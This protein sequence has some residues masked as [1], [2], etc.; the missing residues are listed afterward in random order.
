MIKK[1]QKQTDLL[2]YFLDSSANDVPDR[3]KVVESDFHCLHVGSVKIRMPVFSKKSF[4]T[5]RDLGESILWHGREKVVFN[6]EIEVGHPPIDERV[7]T[8]VHRVMRSVGD[9]VD[10][11]VLRDGRQMRVRHCKVCEN[12]CRSNP[13]VKEVAC[14][15]HAPPKVVLVKVGDNGV[16]KSDPSCFCPLLFADDASWVQ[17][18]GPP[19]RYEEA[20]HG[21]PKDVLIADHEFRQR[22]AR[23]LRHLFT[24]CDQWQRIQIRIMLQLLRGGMMFVVLNPPPPSGHA[25]AKTI[26]EPL[27][28]PVIVQVSSQTPVSSFVH[29][30]AAP[31]LG[32]A[33]N[34][35][36]DERK[37]GICSPEVKENISAEDVHSNKLEDPVSNVSVRRLVV[38]FFLQLL[39]EGL[40]IL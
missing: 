24:K 38:A 28:I 18:H 8:D 32:D 23:L 30:P 20:D 4:D 15:S 11:G 10:V 5:W 37:E 19:S 26:E 36:P 2:M 34:H 22:V 6:L 17:K 16:P 25:T 7:V 3:F 27:N 9:P 1:R 29:E 35:K 39:P 31:T 40:E 13:D 21:E 14:S 12:I 33:Q